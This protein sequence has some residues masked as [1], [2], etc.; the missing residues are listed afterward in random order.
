MTPSLYDFT[1]LSHLFFLLC[2]PLWVSSVFLKI[3]PFQPNE[4]RLLFQGDAISS[5]EAVLFS[6]PQYF[7]SVGWAIYK[8]AVPIWDSQTGKITDFTTHFSFTIDTQQVSNFGHGIAFFLAPPGFQIPPNSAG[9]YLG[10]FNKTYADSSTNQIVHVEFDTFSNEWDPNFEH[11][12]ININSLAS[13]NFTRWNVSFHSGDIIDVWISYNSTSKNLSASW[14]YKYTSNSS[15]DTAL[16]YQI[17]LMKVLPQRATI[18]FSASTGTF[19]EQHSL[20]SWEFNSSL[21]ILSNPTSENNNNKGGKFNIVV[22]VVT[23]LGVLMMI[24]AAVSFTL[25]FR[26]LKQNKRKA[27]EENVEE[28]KLTSI[29]EDFERGAGPRRFSRKLLAMATNNFSNKRKLGEGGFGAVYRGYLPDI[30]STVAVKKV[31]RGSKQGRK[32]YITEVKIISRLRHRNL[33]QLIGWC[34]DKGEFLLVYE[35]MPNGSLDFHL[36]GRRSSHLAWGTRYNI[37]LG[38]ASALLYLHEEWEQ[39][40]IHRDIKSSNIMLDSSF[41]VKLGDFG[42]ARLIDH[43]LGAQTTG[44]VGTL[45]YLAPEYISTGKASKESDIYSFGVVVL[46]IVTGRM[47][48]TVIEEESHKG[49]VEWVWDLYGSGRLLVAVDEKLQSDYD[50]Q[51]VER[52]ML[53]GLWSAHPDPNLRPSIKQAIQVLN[54]ETRIPNLPT[55]MPIPF[56]CAPNFTFMTSKETS[57]T[58][59]L[60]VGR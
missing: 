33:V 28:V 23:P 51:Q 17:D 25:V 27:E 40:V 9:G 4:N 30:D 22:V 53:I 14:K 59:S 8:D 57:I 2:L 49:L 5:Y 6:D 39:C 12:G 20:F 54:F 45:G 42:L 37:A 21:D 43:D 34:H 60:D 18:G 38:L 36:F 11:V 19:L 31:S 56:Y 47:S 10:L 50:K 24:I 46:E 26:R 7:C 44:L 48:R 15:E 32:E 52:L 41:N 55:E 58:V 16:N 1:M 29:N 35:Y 13:S 3:D